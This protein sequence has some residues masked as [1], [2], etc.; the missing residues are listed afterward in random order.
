M[1]EYNDWA[2]FDDAGNLAVTQMM[3]ELKRAIS[4]KPLPEVRRQLH[5]LREEVG[6]KHGEV[7]DSDVRD[8][9][10]SYLTQWAC[11]VHELHPVFGLDYS[12]WQ[13]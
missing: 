4:T 5:Q 7:Y 12:Y 6:K 13:L 11:E 1:Q 3:Y 2:M 8:I 9:I 10:T